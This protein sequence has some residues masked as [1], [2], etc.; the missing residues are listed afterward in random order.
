M[1]GTVVQ[2]LGTQQPP[3]TQ[4][5]FRQMTGEL[6]E[7]NADLPVQ[8]AK[9]FIQNSYRRIVDSRNFYG[10]LVKGQVNVPNATTIGTVAVFNGS[11]NVTGTGT[12]WANS[13]IGQQ[14]RIGFST[15]IYTIVN[16]LSATVLV[17]D[18]PWG[19]PTQAS[20]G[21]QIFQSIV[22]FGGNI[23]RILAAVNQIQGYRLA[24]NIPQEVLNIYDTWRTNMGWTTLV[25]NYA[26]SPTG[27]PQ[28]ELY[29]PPTFQQSFPFLAYTQPPDLINDG[30]SPVVS[31][32][33][34]VIMYGAIP[35]ALLFR[36]KESKY[37]D[38]QT[39]Q[40]Y[41]KMYENELQKNK[42]NDNDLYQKDLIWEYANWPLTGF[43]ASF[44]QSHE[45]TPY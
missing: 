12:A 30:D 20:L 10:M 15:P 17:L 4:L 34:D 25:A 11:N 14:F 6:L 5:N 18:L 44:W 9:R 39:A 31:I 43:G 7:H 32:R 38:P 42:M 21:Y 24:L 2:V 23:K 1:G 40:Y 33:S 37:Y 8:M 27:S 13:L 35:Q 29:P 19:G 36:G 28:F 45:Q 26:P 22:S 3:S 41:Q 16:V